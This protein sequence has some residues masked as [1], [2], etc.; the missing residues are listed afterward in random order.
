[1]KRLFSFFTIIAFL[2]VSFVSGSHFHKD[3]ET[4]SKADCPLCV[5]L[6]TPSVA[7]AVHTV[8]V[9]PVIFQD[10]KVPPTENAVA[11]CLLVVSDPRAPPSFF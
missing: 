1:M 2:S 11:T 7:P 6:Q 5:F 9:V 4:G 3:T 8:P 10:S